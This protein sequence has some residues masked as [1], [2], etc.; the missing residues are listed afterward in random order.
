MEAWE[1]VMYSTARAADG[2]GAIIFFV[3]WLFVGKYILLSLYLAVI[4]EAF[5]VSQSRRV[6]A[7]R[8][9][10]VED[11]GCLEVPASSFTSQ[12][13]ALLSDEPVPGA[14]CEP[15]LVIA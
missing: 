8:K 6:L 15:Q 5:E 2:S 4:M 1:E 12:D 13:P 10:P 3:V 7:A 9:I 14:V 11:C